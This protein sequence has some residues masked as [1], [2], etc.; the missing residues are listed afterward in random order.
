[1]Q[2]TL[3]VQVGQLIDNQQS[4]A[5]HYHIEM[6]NYGFFHILQ[7]NC[8]RHLMPYHKLSLHHVQT[9]PEHTP[10]VLQ[11]FSEENKQV[12][13]EEV[14]PKSEDIVTGKQIGRAH[15]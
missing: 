12:T 9:I 13:K 2:N 7:L 4:L 1:M 10:V 8:E 5:R 6:P 3:A 11:I 14:T 15:V